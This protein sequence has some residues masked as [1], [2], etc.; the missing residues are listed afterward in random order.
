MKAKREAQKKEGFKEGKSEHKSQKFFD[1]K[2]D[3]SKTDG[4]RKQK[5]IQET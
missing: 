1:K 5:R 4:E 2:Q 3:L